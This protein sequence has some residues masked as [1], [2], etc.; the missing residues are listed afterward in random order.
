MT[1][2]ER[3]RAKIARLQEIEERLSNEEYNRH[4]HKQDAFSKLMCAGFSIERWAPPPI[5]DLTQ[6]GDSIHRDHT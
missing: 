1:R 2:L 4:P 6:A 5:T 3:I